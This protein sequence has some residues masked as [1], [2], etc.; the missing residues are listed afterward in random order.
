MYEVDERKG[1][2]KRHFIYVYLLAHMYIIYGCMM[3]SN[4]RV[5]GGSQTTFEPDIHVKAHTLSL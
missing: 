4:R 1:K 5:I 2:M 3:G